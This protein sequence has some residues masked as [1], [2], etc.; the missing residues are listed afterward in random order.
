MPETT[1]PAPVSAQNADPS[2]GAN[3]LP[4]MSV[5]PSNDRSPPEIASTVRAAA[6]LCSGGKSRRSC[7]VLAMARIAGSFRLVG[8]CPRGRKRGGKPG[9]R[10]E[11]RGLQGFGEGR[12]RPCSPNGK[13]DWL[14]LNIWREAAKAC[15]VRQDLKQIGARI[16]GVH[17]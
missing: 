4:A 2:D 13:L 14:L 16:A 1:R 3:R 9:A 5:M 10:A 6:S 15:D 17:Q 7:T 11:R 8:L 12:G